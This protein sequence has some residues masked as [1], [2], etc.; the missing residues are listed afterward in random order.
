[1]GAGSHGF[2]GIS[3]GGGSWMTLGDG[4]LDVAG[5]IRIDGD[6]TLIAAPATTPWPMPAATPSR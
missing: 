1:V 4:D 3:V 6:S 5:Q 2:K